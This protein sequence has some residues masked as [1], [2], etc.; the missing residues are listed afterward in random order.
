MSQAAAAVRKV[1]PAGSPPAGAPR[2]LTPGMK[3][4]VYVP[5][6]LTVD[7]CVDLGRRDINVTQQFLHRD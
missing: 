4:P 3:S 5:Q 2:S 7:M 6:V 1:Q